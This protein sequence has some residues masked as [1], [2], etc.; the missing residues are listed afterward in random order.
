[1]A[2]IKEIMRIPRDQPVPLGKRKRGQ[3][4]YRSRSKAVEEQVKVVP[5]TNPEE[6]WDDNTDPHCTVID[7][8][9]KEL[10]ERR[11]FCLWH[12]L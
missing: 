11:E 8:A 10:V 1:M 4:R 2:P 7:Y 12:L 3:T 9:S 5:V 6:G